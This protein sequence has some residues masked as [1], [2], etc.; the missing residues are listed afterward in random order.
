MSSNGTEPRHISGGAQVATPVLPPAR[1]D[2]YYGRRMGKNSRHTA[3]PRPWSGSGRGA[4]SWAA[5]HRV[6]VATT[7]TVALRWWSEGPSRPG[8][9]HGPVLMLRVLVGTSPG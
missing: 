6:L 8:V 3:T 2:P 9:T 5:R 1:V 7:T 4:P